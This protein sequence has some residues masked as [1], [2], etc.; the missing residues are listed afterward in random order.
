[1]RNKLAFDLM[2]DIPHIH[3][4]RTQFT[5]ITY[6]DGSAD[7]DLGLFAHTEKIGKEYPLNRGYAPTSNIYKVKKHYFEK[8]VRLNVNPTEPES[9]FES[10]LEA[11]HYPAGTQ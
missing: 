1:M 4:L 8:D 5:H 6:N 9:E 11:E 7:S 2:R 3:S 10:G